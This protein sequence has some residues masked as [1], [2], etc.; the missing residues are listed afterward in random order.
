MTATRLKIAALRAMERLWSGWYL[1]A[2]LM[3]GYFSKLCHRQG[4]RG[5]S[6]RLGEK[7]GRVVFDGVPAQLTDATS[8]ELY[9]LEAGEVMDEAPAR[10]REDRIP[11]FGEAAVA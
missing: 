8:R 6:L 5:H 7:S 9:G 2:T 10:A 11:A 1:R 3:P 4:Q